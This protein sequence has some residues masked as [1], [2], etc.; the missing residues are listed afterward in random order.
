MWRARHGSEVTAPPV[1]AIV[2]VL[3]EAR[4][5]GGF[6]DALCAHDFAEII[7]VDGGSDDAT[8][9]IV[10]T[11]RTGHPDNRIVLIESA[12][13]RARQMNAGA[14]QATS[15]ILMFLHADTR[16]P[17]RAVE[18]C[19]T[20]IGGDRAWGRFDV[21]LD[22]RHALL[23]VVAFFMNWRSRLTGICTG[24]QG[25]FVRRDVFERIAGYAEISLME[26]IE[27]SRRLKRITRP[28]CVRERVTT[29]ARRWIEG[30]VL[31]TILHMWW[32]RLRYFFGTLPE[33]I[34]RS[35]PDVREP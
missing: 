32:L 2:P 25:I 10:Q 27:I 11:C 8:R 13:G 14:Q 23:P 24:D 15:G 22:G 33:K 7:V 4:A 12:R 26:D 3:N 30:G 34:A 35:Y 17:D 6:L 31:R 20:A 21:R 19:R 1:A 5:I 28:A 18:N 9:A 29:S 16:L